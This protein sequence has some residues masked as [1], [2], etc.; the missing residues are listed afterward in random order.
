MFRKFPIENIVFLVVVAIIAILASMLLPALNSARAKARSITCVGKLK[1]IGIA[2]TIY[3]KDHDDCVPP[4]FGTNAFQ[5][6]MFNYLGGVGNWEDASTQTQ[7]RYAREAYLCP[8]NP[9]RA[10]T[11]NV[12][13]ATGSYGQNGYV[14][15]DGSSAWVGSGNDHL[16]ILQPGQARFPSRVIYFAD[17]EIG[18]TVMTIVTISG[19]IY[20]LNT[21]ASASDSR[22]DTRHSR[23]ANILWLDSHVETLSLEQ[24]WGRK[25]WDGKK[26]RS[27]RLLYN[28]I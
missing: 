18:G 11:T 17:S 19:S 12:T 4:S 8:S 14:R 10:L 5:K 27:A 24:L 13:H 9:K 2:F 22:I 28:G 1:Q 25:G 15:C 16:Y 26:N 6:S 20:P 3:L 21:A 7:L 23:N